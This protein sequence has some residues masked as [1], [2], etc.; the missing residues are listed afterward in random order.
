MTHDFPSSRKNK[1]KLGLGPSRGR[2]TWPWKAGVVGCVPVSVCVFCLC[3]YVHIWW[4][5]LSPQ[6][7]WVQGPCSAH[8]QASGGASLSL[9]VFSK[10]QTQKLTGFEF[11]Q[12]H[13]VPEHRPQGGLPPHHPTWI[14]KV[15]EGLSILFSKHLFNSYCV[16]HPGLGH[17]P[18]A[19]G[20]S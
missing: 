4:E 20:H 11:C 1:R 19:S 17:R 9:S 14:T 3:V 2:T 12:E 5:R 15:W 16:P 13:S 8:F 6:G 18:R 7:S 10:T